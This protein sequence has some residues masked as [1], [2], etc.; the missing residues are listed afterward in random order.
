MSS[1]LRTFPVCLLAAGLLVPGTTGLALPDDKE[2]PIHI[3][4]EEVVSDEKNRV[5]RYRGNVRIR[6]GSIR[7]AADFVTLYHLDSP[8]D[9]IVAEGQPARMQMQRQPDTEPIHAEGKIIEYYKEQ[10]RLY[11]S[12]QARLEQDGST[13]QSDSIE[14]FINRELVKALADESVSGEAQGR[15]KVVIPPGRLELDKAD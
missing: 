4:S 11:I 8:A 3:E 14:Y 7:I 10:E 12:H 5:T 6:Q 15:V 13:V 9:K 2:Q 1:L